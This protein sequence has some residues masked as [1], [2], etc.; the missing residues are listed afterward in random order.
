MELLDEEIYDYKKA[1]GSKKTEAPAGGPAWSAQVAAQALADAGPA[2]EDF[3]KRPR[4]KEAGMT[5]E[6]LLRSLLK[7]TPEEREQPVNVF[8]YGRDSFLG[9]FAVCA[10]GCPAVHFTV[11]GPIAEPITSKEN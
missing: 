5:F 2:E 4:E 3:P 10:E 11:E 6:D 7:M 1:F 8:D 9:G